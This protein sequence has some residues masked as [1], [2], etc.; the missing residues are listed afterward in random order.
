MGR[1]GDGRDGEK[2]Y[3]NRTEDRQDLNS[4]DR[5]F[6]YIFFIFATFWCAKRSLVGLA[7]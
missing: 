6:V 1:D 7:D 4:L 3:G 5:G 2:K